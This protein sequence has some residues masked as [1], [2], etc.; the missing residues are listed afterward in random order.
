MRTIR[1]SRPA[2]AAGVAAAGAVATAGPAG[3]V[4]FFQRWCLTWGARDDEVAAQLPGDELLPDAGLVTTRA[5]TIDAPPEAIWPWLVQMG[6]GRG[7]AYSYDWIENLLGLNM[8][9]A[10]EILPRYQHI[11]VGDELPMG[12]GRPVPPPLTVTV[13]RGNSSFAEPWRPRLSSG[14]S[15]SRGSAATAYGSSTMRAVALPCST[16]AMAS[17]TSASGLVS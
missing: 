5:V 7:G 17:L 12:P 8:H 1:L 10:N 9:S 4:L 11:A 3:Y 13:D 14:T 2:L 6:S 16:S 15:D